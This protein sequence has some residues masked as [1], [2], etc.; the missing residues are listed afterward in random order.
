MGMPFAPCYHLDRRV[1]WGGMPLALA[2]APPSCLHKGLFEQPNQMA[3]V[4]GALRFLNERWP[5]F[6]AAQT[7]PGQTA[8]PLRAALFTGEQM[9]THGLALAGRHVL[10]LR[11]PRDRLLKRLAD[12]ERVLTEVGRTLALALAGGATVTPAAEWLLDNLYLIEQ[13]ILAARRHLPRGYSRELPRLVEDELLYGQGAGQPRIYDLA[14]T[15]VSHSDGRLA[16][17]TLSVFLAAYQQQQPLTLGELWAFPIMLRLALIENL[18]RAAESVAEGLQARARADT[19]ATQILRVAEEQPSQLIVVVADLA[20]SPLPLRTAFVSDLARRLQGRGAVLA[21]P[22]SWLEQRLADQGQTIESMFRDDSRVQAEWQLTVA[23][24]IGS[25][26]LVSSTDWPTFVEAASAMER[27]LSG[28]PAGVYAR[29]D[30]ASRDAYRHAVER[31]A[32]R[33]GLDEIEVAKQAIA[34]ATQAA[35]AA[36]GDAVQAHVGYHLVGRGSAALHRA[37]GLRPRPQPR[38]ALRLY[39]GAMFALTLLL[40]AGP[41][42]LAWQAG[43]DTLPRAVWP[44]LWLL[45]AVAASQLALAL[46]N[47]SVT[48]L[49]TP[50]L[51]PRLDFAFGI[52]ADAATLVVVPTLL[53]GADNVDA[54]VGALEVHHLANRDAMLRFALLTDWCDADA[55]STPG[56]AALLERAASGVATLNRRHARPGAHHD[57]F[58]LLHRPR[59]WHA[60]EGAWMAHERKRGKLHDL[61]ALLRGRASVG[62]GQAFV[63][64]EGD[65]QGLTQLRYVITL[66]SDTELPQGAA[67]QLVATMAHP[68]QQPQLG[69]GGIVTAGHAILQP[70]SAASLP[71]TLRSRHAWLF[72][73]DAGIDPYT[74]AVSDVYQDL[75]DEGS[76]IGKGIY[77]IDAFE[78]A[79]NGRLPEGRVLSHDLIEGCH[80]RAGLLSD[81]TLYEPAPARHA[82]EAAR[83]HRWT[84]GDWQLLPWLGR[85]VGVL[86]GRPRN[87]LSALSQWKLIDNLRRSLVPAAL[88]ALLLL[89]WL[90]LP[91]PLLWT[92]LV[93][94][95]LGLVPMSVQVTARLRR[96]VDAGGQ[97][98]LVGPPAFAAPAVR[99]LQQLALLPDEARLLLDAVLRTVWRLRVSRRRLLAWT[100]SANLPRG[101]LPGSLPALREALRMAPAGPLLAVATTA[102]LLGLRPVALPAAAPLLLLW[103]AAPLLIWWLDQPATDRRASL[104]AADRLFLRGVARRTWAF[105]EA[106][107]DAANHHLPPDNVQE[108]PTP[109]TAHRTSPTNIGFSL[110]APLAARDL[111]YI[112]PLQLL[113][114]TAATLQT[115]GQLERHRGHF[116]NWYDTQTLQP[117]TPRYVSAVD[118]GNLAAT[119]LVLRTGLLGL[120][121]EPLFDGRWLNGLQDSLAQLREADSAGATQHAS[122]AL[123]ARLQALAQQPGALDGLSGLRDA[124]HALQADAAAVLAAAAS[125]EAAA[126]ARVF[127]AAAGSPVLNSPN[128]SNSP[129]TFNTPNTPN[130]LNTLNTFGIADSVA[131]AA[132]DGIDSVDTTGPDG[133]AG[134]LRWARLLAQQCTQACD[135]L[136]AL[137]PAPAWAEAAATIT[138]ATITTPSLRVLAVHAHATPAARAALQAVEAM[139]AQALAFTDFEYGFLYDEKRRLLSIGW[140]VDEKRSDAGS[141]DLLASEARLGVFV[142][143]AQGQLPQQAW[144]ALGRGLS[145][146]QGRPVLLSWSGSMFEYLMPALLMPQMP[147]T[148]LEESN[149]SAVR[150]Q[151]E[152]GDERGVPWGISESGYNATDSAL[153]YQYRAFG[154]PGLGLKRGLGDDMVVAPYATL[155]ALIVDPVRATAN[156]RRM[157]EMGALGGFGFYEA[158]DFTAQRVPHGQTHAVVRSFMVHHQGM[159]LLGLAQ[160]LTGPRM[161]QRFEADPELRAALPLLHEKVPTGE[162]P[163]AGAAERA[164]LR[165]HEAV[166]ADE[167]E[168]V[169]TSPDTPQPEVQLLSNGRYHVL[170]TQSGG[171]SSR[172]QGLALTRWRED[173][174]RDADG[175]FCYLRDLESGHVWS[176]T[177]QPTRVAARRSEVVFSESRAEFRRL[178]HGI[179][180][181]TTVAVSPEDDI[182]LRRVRLRNVSRERRRIELTS[183]AEIVLAAASADVQH[184]AFHKLFVQ[185]ELLPRQGAVLAR[186]RPRAEGEEAPWA[187]FLLAV[188]GLDARASWLME[189]S[190]ETDRAR[191]IG[192]GRDLGNPLA[193]ELPGPLSGTAGAVLDPVAASRC[194]LAIEPERT[195]VVDLVTGIAPTR[196]ACLAL[197]DKY[198]DRRLADRVFELAWTHAQ[199]L[200]RQLDL[201]AAEAQLYAQLA[202]ALVY[203][204]G[205]PRAAEALIRANRRSQSGLWG[206]LISGDLPIVLLTISDASHIDLVRQ[207]VQAHAWWRQKG[208]AVD[209]VIWNEEH[210]TYRQ[211]LHEEIL[212]LVAAGREANA[213]DKPGGIFIRHADQIAPEDRTLLMAVARAVFSDRRGTLAEQL[214]RSR[215]AE[216]RRAPTLSRRSDTERRR[217]PL[218]PRLPSRRAAHEAPAARAAAA[219]V[220]L[221]LANGSGGFARTLGGPAQGAL[222][223]VV[224]PPAGTTTPAPWANVLANPRLGSVVSEAGS[225]YTWFGNAHEFRL[226]PWHNDPVCDSSGEASYLRDEDTGDV[227]SP[228]GLPAGAA[229]VTTR[230]GFGRTVFEQTAHGVRSELTLCV[231]LQAPVRLTVLRLTNLSREARRLSATVYVEW[232]LG[233]QRATSAPHVVSEVATDAAC[234]G[235]LLARNAFG[236]DHALR[237]AFLDVDAEHWANPGTSMTCDRGDFL[238]RHGAPSAPQA[239][240]ETRLSG[241]S[242]AALDPCAAIQVPVVLGPGE[243]R[244][245]VFRLGAGNDAAEAA[246]LIQAFRAPGATAQALAAVQ[247]H[248]QGLLG[249]VQVQ[250]PDPALDALANGWLIYQVVASRLWGRSGY[251]QSGGAYGFR[252]QLQDAMALVHTRPDLLREQLLRS[253]ARQF[254]QG[255]VQHWW[256]PPGGR[257]VR[258]HC[259]DD[260]LFLPLALARYVA[261]TG[262]AAVLQQEV[263]FIEG[264]AVPAGEEAYFDL[265]QPSALTATLYEHARRAVLHGLRFGPHGLPLMGS[266]DWNDGMNRVGHQG[267]G[268][269][270]WLAWFLCRVL[271][272][273]EPLARSQHDAA[274]AERCISERQGLAERIEAHAWDGAWYRRAWFDNGTPLGSADSAEC[275]IDLIAQSW[276]VLSGVAPPERTAQALLAMRSQ[277]VDD[278]LGIVRLLA[279]P[280]DGAGPDPGYIAGYVPGVRENGGQYTH[281]AV[282]AAMALAED[283]QTEEAWRLAAMINPLNHARNAEE[284]AVY[285]VEP[286]VVAADVYGVAPHAG[287][288]GWTWYTGSAGWVYRLFVETLLG[289]TL[290]HEAGQCWLRLAPRLPAAWPGF[291]FSYRRGGAMWQVQ[292]RRGAGGSNALEVDAAVLPGNCWPLHDDGLEHQV[293][294]TLAAAP[295]APAPMASAGPLAQLGAAAGPAPTAAPLAA[296]MRAG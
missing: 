171:G 162:V 62:P 69:P 48:L 286:Y 21:M 276:S 91:M 140:N 104:T 116:Y 89:G 215:R 166:R 45:V 11:A 157:A 164:M 149:L 246:A 226:T 232:V 50:R 274:F 223:Y 36:P 258:T 150:R 124:L 134:T 100:A 101:A 82:S 222:E 216:R 263:L 42:A 60:R 111:G 248:W 295:P 70:R 30:F 102:A 40:T 64:T 209:L 279:P 80:A 23:N 115:L 130:T 153:N 117:L 231:D 90:L 20:R 110:L 106:H 133:D 257:G 163:L 155:M 243:T 200:L 131:T 105:F 53:T 284:V 273:F 120:A 9:R 29:M 225:A 54:L 240:R 244:E 71:S 294:Y 160:A 3:S 127:D 67:A 24:S 202:G 38:A 242:G 128:A 220:P 94:A 83:M 72:G 184:P 259:S 28:D 194:V 15:A 85:R 174:T 214:Q 198:R 212:G 18:R 57:I 151:I 139:A 287:R 219:H 281:A 22:L 98:T 175:S 2:A 113:A 148:L 114:R 210:D 188:H 78:A 228:T 206:Y 26:R 35:Q 250:T 176:N 63:R 208:L 167:D 272:D 289:I 237:V 103:L 122:A 261:T 136:E 179:E 84:R 109:R 161:Q 254:P 238:G 56:D 108:Q 181:R 107:V 205:A 10:A 230:H 159:A 169:F 96:L 39:L 4:K 118:S 180:T 241:R 14:L 193:L 264:R 86:P 138:L 112:A 249:A 119:L 125:A 285:K 68:L 73:S 165:L 262:D 291:A 275:N 142:G 87:P 88:L 27:V 19:W 168:R 51:L 196:E 55:E 25:L 267:R 183:Y 8:A 203:A 37:L 12:N 143:V 265:P 95:V 81:V 34:R 191:F 186:R 76:Y 126:A 158:L 278:A 239:L 17:D 290:E 293:L 135:D 296:R 75:F 13:E 185:T 65:L 256:H 132:V 211:R 137:V 192:R 213:I 178:D 146:V 268:E 156:L 93:V 147:G 172:W 129:N 49:T 43:S 253:A 247:A 227:W 221:L 97:P 288:G 292:V 197:I 177:H 236:Q 44:V 245:I 207:L 5:R 145:A 144:F 282:W 283:G 187:F 224:D 170:L 277:L 235:A 152:Y 234:Q 92:V 74:R 270:V 195:R 32:H 31:L 260:Y 182:E 201:S 252:D 233:S 204:Q 217:Q 218:A 52:A 190:H 266:G 79:L 121:D 66:D 7:T 255:D 123:A 77:D 58:F 173:A 141:Y 46:V 1:D 6:S 33:T 16:I 47:W 280:F 251:Y 229:P 199:V 99:L 61:N 59:R 154:V 189:I 271:A 41:L 269:S